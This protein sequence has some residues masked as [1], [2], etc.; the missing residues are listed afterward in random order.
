MAP[1]RRAKKTASEEP[2][3]PAKSKPTISK[4]Q[5]TPR[6]TST[7]KIPTKKDASILSGAST[8]GTLLCAHPQDLYLH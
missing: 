1:V 3:K 4:P 8:V 7:R 5:S 6:R 2:A